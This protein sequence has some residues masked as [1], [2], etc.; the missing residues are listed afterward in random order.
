MSPPAHE[1]AKEEDRLPKGRD[2]APYKYLPVLA[3]AA[4][5]VIFVSESA[6]ALRPLD[7]IDVGLTS[8]RS[9]DAVVTPI[10]EIFQMRPK[11]DQ[12]SGIGIP[13]LPTSPDLLGLRAKRNMRAGQTDETKT[14]LMRGKK[15]R[16]R[17]KKLLL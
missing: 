7:T 10:G 6:R 14:Q 4:V 15:E 12:R 9:G 13:T 2:P 3:C 11:S 16:E 5:I 8:R 1:W 17:K